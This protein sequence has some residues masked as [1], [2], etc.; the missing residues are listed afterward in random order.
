MP[1]IALIHALTHSISPINEE[2]SRR[3]PEASLSNLLDD[4]LSADLVRDGG[5]AS[6][7]MF[8]RFQAL[9]DY[10]VFSGAEAILFTCSA[11]GSCI[12][13]VAARHRQLPILRPN[14][15]MIEEALRLPGPIGL[16]ASFEPTLQSMLAEFPPGTHVETELAHGA[17]AALN[18]NDVA[19]HDAA[20][21]AAAHRL[22]D[23]GVWLIA[24]AQFSLARAAPSV[25]EALDIPVLTTVSSALD[26]LRRRVAG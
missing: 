11:F 22:R 12:D 23:R 21:V 8:Q 17:L 26:A 16:I 1:R 19:T 4:S 25:R 14:E 13:A 7:A 2:F 10:A 3:W 18:R 9:S 15:A 5:K 20:V 6:A 24:L